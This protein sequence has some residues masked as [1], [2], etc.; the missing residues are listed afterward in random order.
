MFL[1]QNTVST[2]LVDMCSGV[3]TNQAEQRM[4]EFSQNQ[5]LLADYFIG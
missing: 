2:M 4:F 5:D 1:F 3:L